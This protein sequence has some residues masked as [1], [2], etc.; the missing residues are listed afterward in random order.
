MKYSKRKIHILVE[1]EKELELWLIYF[2]HVSHQKVNILKE[3]SEIEFKAPI[4]REIEI[5]FEIPSNL[6]VNA[7]LI[8]DH[9]MIALSN[10]IEVDKD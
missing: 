6:L 7:V 4:N 1:C 3:P 9:Y 10:P 2:V 8:K 5:D